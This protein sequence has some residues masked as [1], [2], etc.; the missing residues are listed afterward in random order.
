MNI[1]R[2]RTRESAVPRVGLHDGGGVAELAGVASLAELWALPLAGLRARL[3]EGPSGDQVPLAD[4]ELLAP[5]DGR[6][7]VWAA[8]VTYETSREA[9]VEESERAATVY[10][11]V[12]DAERPELFF[13]SAAWRAVG[14]GGSLSIRSDS[15]VDVP[16]PELALMVNHLGEIVGY[17]VCD[18]VSS[19]SIEGENP[20]YL[21]QAKTY[22][23]A[24]GL[25]P[26]ITPAWE[27]QDPYDLAIE[28]TIH[29]DGRSEWSGQAS[30][31]RLRRRLD[32]LVSYLMRGD[33]HPD[34]VVLSTGTCLV[35]PAP[36]TL[37][38][39]DVV[40]IGI[41]E[42]GTLRNTIIRGKPDEPDKPTVPKE[43][44]LR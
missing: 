16:E 24:C 32:G 17:T 39:G 44:S 18:D 3:A 42:V 43:T 23:G 10:E 6:T 12:Y 7:E 13:K 22:F 9:R 20:L 33:V 8:G 30:T 41:G 29:R 37:A 21:P 38:H 28:M 4:V 36:F 31:S 15:T 35:P 34:G 27:V 26:W 5:V 40:E 25:G 19:R 11:L 1:I 14:P 2:Y